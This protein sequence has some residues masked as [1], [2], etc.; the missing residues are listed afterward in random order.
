MSD[1]PEYYKLASGEEFADYSRRVLCPFLEDAGFDGF[2]IHCIVSAMEHRFRCGRK[3]SDTGHDVEAMTYW[4]SKARRERSDQS[5][6]E[7]VLS[8][9]RHF[10]ITERDQ[11]IARN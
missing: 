2:T 8:S 9:I 4:E 5:Y 10:V 6:F 1:C 7:G 3:S 11:A